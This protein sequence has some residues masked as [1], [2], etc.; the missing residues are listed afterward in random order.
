MPRRQRT[1]RGSDKT[2]AGPADASGQSVAATP[3]ST[4]T[5]ESPLSFNIVGI[6]ASAGGI[7][8]LSQLLQALPV[9]TG[10]AF[11]I[12]QHLDPSHSSMLA[13]ILGRRTSMAVVEC[14]DM[15]PIETNH[16]Y[17][18][19][20]GKD[21]TVTDGH[22]QLAPR[23][24]GRGQHRP[25][26]LFFRSLAE[27]EGFRAIGVILSGSSSDGTLGLEEI[28]AV[29]GI[30]FA[31]DDTAEHATM[32]RSAIAAGCVD[33]VLAPA[34]IAAEI[35]RASRHPYLNVAAA[36]AQELL[37]RESQLGHVLEILRHST[38]V[39][40][41]NYK[42][43]TLHR[44]ISRRMLL[45]RFES[46]KDYLRFL[47]DTPTEV[48]ALYQDILINVTSFF[49]DPEAYEVLKTKVFPRLTEGKSRNDH[50]RV[51]TLG[52]STGE[53]AYSIAMAY[54][55]F[56][57]SSA[58]R[59][60]LQVFATDLNGTSIERARAGIY[61]KGIAHDLTPERLRRFF[62]EVDGSYRVAKAIRDVCIFARQNVLSDPPF[63]RMDL[64]SCRNMLI[65]LEPVLQQRLL[66]I[67][68][69]SL[70]P[71]G[72]L[73][74]GSSETI[75]AYRDLFEI[76]DTRNKIY[77]KKAGSGR[78]GER[79][80]YQLLIPKP[81]RAER[82]GEP[83]PLGP[84]DA[85][86]EADRILL[87][88]YAPPGVVINA[89][90]EIQQFRGDTSAFLTPA[91]G[92]ASLHLLK[93]LREGLLVAVRGAV[94]RARREKLAVRQPGLRV[95]TETGFREVDV[96]V[97]PI[98][99]GAADGLLLV[100]FEPAGTTKPAP[101]PA[102][103]EAAAA[104]TDDAGELARLRQE[105]DSTREYLQSLIEQQEAANEELQSANEEVQST[106]EELQSINE[107]LETSKEEIQSSNE[108][109]ATVNDQLQNR[110]L[111]L[112]QVNNDLVN[113]LASVQMPIVMLG[114]DLRIRHFTP[115]AEKLL[116]LI[117]TDVG[118]PIG[119]IKLSLTIENF[120][121]RLA[122]V[123]DKVS[124]YEEL[125]QDKHGRWHSLRIHPYKTLENVIDGAVLVLVD[126]DQLKRA[127]SALA[128]SE[129][130]YTR[131][132]DSSQHALR[133]SESRFA[134]LADS[135]PVLI[136]MSG[137][138][139]RGYVN[140]A[141]LD[142]LGVDESKVHGD[143]WM[144]YIHPDDREKYF[145]LY[146]EKIARREPFECQC[147]L[148]RV[149]GVYR[150]MKVAAVP[151]TAGNDLV[152]Y[153][154][155]KTDITDL[156]EAEQTLRE[157]DRGKNNFIAMLAHELR[158]P[159]AAMRNAV[160]VLGYE[161]PDPSLAARAQGVIERQTAQMVRVVDDLLDLSRLTRGTF[162]LRQRQ[163]DLLD[164]VRQA[165]E[166]TEH[167]RHV[168]SQR[169]TLQ[170]PDAPILLHVDMARMQQVFANL[171][172]NASRYTASYG[173]VQVSVE[174]EPAPRR[175]RDEAEPV[176]AWA[177]VRIR[178]NGIG[179][180]PAMLERIF[181]LFAQSEDPGN[182]TGGGL[183][184]GLNLARRLVE[185]HGGSISAESGGRDKGSEFIV[186]L[187]V[188]G[189][190]RAVLD[191]RATA[192]AQRT[193]D[194]SAPLRVL[195]VDDNPD[196]ADMLVYLLQLAGQKVRAANDGESAL[197]I[198]GEFRP[199]LVLLD[200]SMPKVDGR[201]VARRLRAD[202]ATK[203][204]FLVAV[205]GFSPADAVLDMSP[206]GF[207]ARVTKPLENDAL[208]ALIARVQNRQP[209]DAHA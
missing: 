104:A 196:A 37:A 154:G 56:A 200:I 139:G 120:E 171:L 188:E 150:W 69:Y 173:S 184:I 16:V 88:R 17:V 134:R 112:T 191:A 135:A 38:G 148:R 8:A 125:V 189:E 11:V 109:L 96:T 193:L 6:G 21:M 30:T 58:R 190:D 118:R 161:G 201:E 194:A 95:K 33:F 130:R 4:V 40:F 54:A 114:R 107:E 29:G 36:E 62:V 111:E 89:S 141:Y 97:I 78:S 115:S 167:E 34:D 151:R 71:Q 41:A 101:P 127:Q 124:V 94:H 205:T 132:S 175:E 206:A 142:F 68:H 76:E 10:M 136:W 187:P 131:L 46:L 48:E 7:E 52:C 31:Q 144:N 1:A 55:E 3:A 91:P 122:E 13:E 140:R 50:V 117:P 145:T 209:G 14:A 59:I 79:V 35:G 74:L 129:G 28:K 87:Q 82:S 138:Q 128:E 116:N 172:G 83:P 182:E 143:G 162:R 102:V 84:L 186:R 147:R 12:V 43:N 163:G 90:L 23:S 156:K 85:L 198:A 100:T 60:P 197:R 22:L 165:V 208:V 169:L 121:Q 177:V 73:W 27:R 53:E 39:D 24:A 5:Q 93:M 72:F 159:L 174:R 149:D 207:D 137:P 160:Q 86:K 176:Q 2:D 75:G 65:Y 18:I 155:C 123:V 202:A 146:R 157:A 105:I 119:D 179:I 44:R 103:T 204:A 9:D 32:P 192:D 63:S 64:I 15:T 153:L 106:N 98:N 61:P 67:L 178:D 152:G 195:V 168:K 26:D 19:P 49:R 110:N 126:V 45:H 164:A 185:L 99:G 20:P 66:P 181:D 77:S 166:T 81:P 42:R 199:Q 80:Q 180:E 203:D 51:W 108:E 183:G 133:E 158:T 57:E 92:R 47:Q 170:L 25:I 70:Q 113:L